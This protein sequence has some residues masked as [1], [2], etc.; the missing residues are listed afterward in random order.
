MYL[1]VLLFPFLS[2]FSTNLFG[3]IIGINGSNILATFS[4]LFSF[5]L[6]IF[7]F[8]ESALCG[9]ICTLVVTT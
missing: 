7:I 8:Y 2:Y 1:S 6:S 5:V 4:I 9:S 3:R